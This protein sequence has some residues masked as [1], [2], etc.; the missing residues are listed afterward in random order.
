MGMAV[1]PGDSGRSGGHSENHRFPLTALLLVGLVSS[2]LVVIGPTSGAQAATAN[3]YLKGGGVPEADLSTTGP[4][5]ASLPNYDP[6][7]DDEPGLLLQKTDGGWGESDANKY[8]VWLSTS[9]GMSIDGPVTLTFWSAMKD[10]EAK[11]GHVEAFLLDCSTNGGS[12]ILID[13]ASRDSSPWNQSGSWQK[14]TI[15]FGSVAYTLAG[16]RALALKIV[17]AD[18]SDDDM[19]IAYGSTTY[20]S[21]LSV[22]QGTPVTTTT[23]TSTT[24]ISVNTTTVPV[25]TSTTRASSPTTVTTV[26]TTSTTE[27]SAES[28]TTTTIVA[29][30]ARGPGS[31]PGS[32]PGGPPAGDLEVA[33]PDN[34]LFYTGTFLGVA[35]PLLAAMGDGDGGLSAS[36]YLADSWT[37]S[38]IQGLELVIPRWAVGVVTSPLMVLG[39]VFDAMTDSGK[40]I[41]LPVSLLAAGLLWVAFENRIFT[42]AMIR[43]NREERGGPE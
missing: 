35:D 40:A 42:L 5:S 26:G 27:V 41:M 8:Q 11:R 1:N 38:I 16:D 13:Q 24:T 31:G 36:S 33:T 23:S 39:F 3:H 2:L 32:G 25:T 21:S 20:P 28:S 43:R 17:V 15:A 9:P 34:P 29:T 10:F 6:G 19:W 7:R 18:D 22:Q 12:C 4:T 14:Q 30:G 37:G